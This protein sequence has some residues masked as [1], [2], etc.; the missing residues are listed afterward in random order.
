VTPHKALGLT[1]IM[2]VWNTLF[3]RFLKLNNSFDCLIRSKLKNDSKRTILTV[4]LNLR[5]HTKTLVPL[6]LCTI[7]FWGPSQVSQSGPAFVKAGTRV[8]WR[9]FLF[10]TVV[11][12]TTLLVSVDIRLVGGY[13]ITGERWKKRDAKASGRGIIQRTGNKTARKIPQVGL[14]IRWSLSYPLTPIN[15]NW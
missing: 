14:A 1:V 15:S 2:R 7:T 4:H 12:C 5:A 8:R 9:Q 11:N 6:L 13:R 10:N 3:T